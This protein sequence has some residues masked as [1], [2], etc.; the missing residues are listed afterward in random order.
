M[1]CRTSLSRYLKFGSF[2]SKFWTLL[3]CFEISLTGLDL[4]TDLDRDR[5][6][7]NDLDFDLTLLLDTL[8][9]LLLLTD[10]ETLLDMLLLLLIDLDLDTL[11]DF[12]VTGHLLLLPDLDRLLDEDLETDLDT[13]L[14]K[15]P[16]ENEK[17]QSSVE[18]MGFWESQSPQYAFKRLIP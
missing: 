15:F 10:L 4:S 17:S 12:L 1:G 3:S 6:L 8:L 7:D 5:E 18:K 13:E 9:L 16:C 2:T 14:V 11:L